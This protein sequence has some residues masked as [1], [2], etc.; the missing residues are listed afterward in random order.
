ML[1][2]DPAA[3]A[4]SRMRRATRDATDRPSAPSCWALS[5]SSARRSSSAPRTTIAT[6]SSLSSSK[7][8]SQPRTS[9]AGVTS[10]ATDSALVTCDA[11]CLSCL[12]TVTRRTLPPPTSSATLDGSSLMDGARYRSPR[13]RETP[14]VP[15]SLGAARPAVHPP[16]RLRTASRS[17][18]P[19]GLWSTLSRRGGPLRQTRRVRASPTFAHTTK[20]R[21]AGSVTIATAARVVPA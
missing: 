15:L 13:E 20:E 14:S 10:G 5:P 2:S 6:C 8:P 17:S 18:A 1:S 12:S 16:G 11:S 7:T 21:S 19:P 3:N 9:A 4:A